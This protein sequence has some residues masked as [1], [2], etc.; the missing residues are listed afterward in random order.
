MNAES[1]QMT[2]DRRL[3]VLFVETIRIIAEVLKID[4]DDLLKKILTNPEAE[5]LLNPIIG[6]ELKKAG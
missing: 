1:L 4:A 2:L 6:N 5:M 3:W